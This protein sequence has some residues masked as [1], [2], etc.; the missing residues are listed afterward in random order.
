MPGSG[1]NRA[2]LWSDCTQITDV[3]QEDT[4]TADCKIVVRLL[5]LD[6][7]CE[8]CPCKVSTKQ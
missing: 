5:R 8:L 3:A 1:G 7:T 2:T 6:I 4:K